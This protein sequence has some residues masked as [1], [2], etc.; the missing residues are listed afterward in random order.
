MTKQINDVS[1][2]GFYVLRYFNITVEAKN[3]FPD[4]GDTKHRLLSSKDYIGENVRDMV[5]MG[6]HKG[7]RTSLISP[8]KP[9][10]IA[11][12]FQSIWNFW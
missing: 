4:R 2:F 6:S 1:I 12:E 8:C 5:T 7:L 11:G 9:D 3:Y 10:L